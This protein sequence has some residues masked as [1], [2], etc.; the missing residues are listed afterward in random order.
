MKQNKYGVQVQCMCGGICC[1]IKQ[2]RGP[3]ASTPPHIGA[4]AHVPG[5]PKIGKV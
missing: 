5:Q 2:T 1:L 4:H 3:Y